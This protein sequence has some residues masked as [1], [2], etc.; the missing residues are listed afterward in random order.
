MN[1]ARHPRSLHLLARSFSLGAWFAILLVIG[2]CAAPLG[3]QMDE[4]ESGM[5]DVWEAIYGSGLDPMADDDGDGFPNWAEALA[6]T[7]PFD[8]NCYPRSGQ[9]HRVPG[10]HFLYAWPTVPGVGYQVEVSRDLRHWESIGEVIIGQPDSSEVGLPLDPL[11]TFLGSGAHRDLW[12]IS[13]G[14]L[15]VVKNLAAEYTPPDESDH[16]TSLEIPQSNPNRDH[17]GQW[18]RGWIVPAE[19]GEHVFWLAS[20]D[21]AELWLSSDAD[22]ENGSL[23]AYVDGW[24][25]FREW[26]KFSSQES[27]PMY[28]VENTAYYFELFHREYTGG[29]HFSI[30]WTRPSD[31]PGTRELISTPHLSTTGQSLADLMADGGRLFFRQQIVAVD[32]D[33]DGL[34]DYEEYLLGLDPHNATTQ[35][36]LD[37][38][39]NALRILASENTL[40]A[41]ALVPRAYESSGTPAV[42][43]LQR[44]G[45][46]APLTVAY[47]LAGTAGE[48]IDYLPLPGTVEF[49]P[50]ERSATIEIHPI[51]DDLVEPRESVILTIESGEGYVVGSPASATVYIDD[52]EDV[53]YVAQLRSA[54]PTL[55]GG[56]GTASV[57]RAGNSLGATLSLSFGGLT[58]SFTSAEIYL[59]ADGLSGPIVYE[60]PED[61][62]IPWEWDL[63]PVNGI[64]REA[65]LA[66]LDAGEGWVRLRST[67]FLDG[68]IRGRLVLAPAF[69]EM[70]A[71]DLPL[72]SPDVADSLGEAARFLTQATFGPTPG[73]TVALADSSFSQW[74]ETQLALPPT[75]HLPY[76]QA[77]RA[78]LLANTGSDGWQTPRQEAWWENALHA[79]DQLRQ[80]MAFALSQILVIS[81]EGALD[82]QHEASARYYDLL[83][84]H[85]FGNYR[86]LLEEVTLSPMM[87]VYLSMMRNRRPDPVTGHEPDENYAREIMQLFTIGL[88]ELHLDGSLRLNPEGHPIPTYT[89]EDTSELAHIFTGWGPHY[90]P[91]DPPRWSNGSIATPEAWFLY[92]FDPDRPMSFYSQYH[93][94]EDRI[95]IGGYTIPGELSGEARMQAALDH[96]FHHPNLAPFLARQ[97]IQKFVTS[98]PSPGYIYRVASAF[99]DNGSGIRGDLGA[100]IRAVLLDYEA[101]HPQV[102]SRLAYGK[103]GEPILRTARMLRF[104]PPLPPLAGE[105]DQRLFL[106][107]RYSIPEQA[108]LHSPSVFNFFQPGYSAPGA[109]TRAGL[110]SP[111][112]QI[113]AET[114]AIRQANFKFNCLFWGIWTPQLDAAGN[115]AIITL[116]LS[117]TLAILD[118]PDLSPQEGQSALLDYLD[119]HL[120]FGA[121][122][123]A[124]RADIQSAFDNLP[125]WFDTSP[126][127]QLARIRIAAW[128]VVNSPE[129]WV[130]R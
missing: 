110:L 51:D 119:A 64:S 115:N 10:G 84:D 61:T 95:L 93:D 102:R 32:S 25:G 87:G 9:L 65:L 11:T 58:G 76:T 49:G 36:R 33:G 77:R 6:G 104:F 37:D 98:N 67:A 121:M 20:D 120:L 105:G 96:L 4:N 78:E 48:G 16:L 63:E 109:I 13:S 47:S 8:P 60:F 54:D 114:T 53:L 123:S 39:E 38:R 72:P 73:E 71:P 1:I 100:T 30:A 91:A 69:A 43:L 108:P 52:A 2:I 15:N 31:E 5:S 17:F 125:G 34:T 40:T 124:L 44:S 80:R 66:A 24:T 118:Q 113:F 82:I 62:T 29:D 101:R 86:D 127:R 56:S 7:N 111:E 35:P 116:D 28:L 99:E 94:F 68:E 42:I 55:S 23:V 122:S 103:P 57:R 46:I 90:D 89:Q 128:L 19:T 92:G 112:L 18:V 126:D 88:N 12:N 74:I 97:L 27:E 3:A 117:P 14:G 70:P 41:S 107:T 21:H 50:G 75:Y 79:P 129:F 85:A 22:P 45:G 130:Q 106:S 26:D 59:S 83:L 81:Q